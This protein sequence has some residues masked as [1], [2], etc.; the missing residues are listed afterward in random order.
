V[1]YTQD[2][3]GPSKGEIR[4]LR[5]KK[6]VAPKS[7]RQYHP[8][9]IIGRCS[10][11]GLVSTLDW[12][13]GTFSWNDGDRVMEYYHINSVQCAHPAKGGCGRMVQFKPI[14][15]RNPTP[16]DLRELEAIYKAQRELF[17]RI[18]R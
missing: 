16:R 2:R 6:P 1:R 12:P 17:R 14:D 15:L 9:D 13:P 4:Y 3:K 7:T 11:C 18:G 5:A 10:E 8:G